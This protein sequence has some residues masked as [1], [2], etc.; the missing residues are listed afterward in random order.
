MARADGHGNGHRAGADR[1]PTVAGQDGKARAATGAVS[2]AQL[3]GG[4]KTQA[5]A[6]ASTAPP[7]TPT[8]RGETRETPQPG[9]NA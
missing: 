5:T 7:D 2:P 8:G 3:A 6:P 4:D 9:M 1:E